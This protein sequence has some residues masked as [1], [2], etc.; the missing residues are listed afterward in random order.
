MDEGANPDLVSD[1]ERDNPGPSK[2]VK[3]SRKVGAAVYR[4]RFNHAWMK[5]YPFV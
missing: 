4:T 1:S 5:T 2:R 3:V